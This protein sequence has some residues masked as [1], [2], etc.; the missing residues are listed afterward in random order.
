MF[1]HKHFLLQHIRRR[2]LRRGARCDGIALRPILVPATAWM[3]PCP[4][5][6]RGL[7]FSRNV[8]ASTQTLRM[9]RMGE[10]R[11]QPRN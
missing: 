11:G 8:S 1:K 3:E 10:A 5:K 6:R 7:R 4:S 2:L 9:E